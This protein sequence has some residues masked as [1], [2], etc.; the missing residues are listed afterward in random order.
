MKGEYDFG[1]LCEMFLK[2]LRSILIAA[3]DGNLNKVRGICI[4]GIKNL[5][6]LKK[7]RGL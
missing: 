1:N 6:R 4:E 7:C 2:C 5:E 3:Q